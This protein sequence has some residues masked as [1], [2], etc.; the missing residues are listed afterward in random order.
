LRE[1]LRIL[2]PG[3]TLVVI[4]ND[5]RHGE[6]AELLRASAWAQAQGTAVS[7]DAWWAG[8]A[9]RRTEVMSS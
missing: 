5:W 8:H 3:G 4:D 9:A 6:F 2:R 7:T 1:V